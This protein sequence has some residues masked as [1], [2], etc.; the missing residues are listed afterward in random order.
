MQKKLACLFFFITPCLYRFNYPYS[1][2]QK[3]WISWSSSACVS[4]VTVWSLLHFWPTKGPSAGTSGMKWYTRNGF[5]TC[6]REAF[7]WANLSKW[8]TFLV[9]RW[10][11]AGEACAHWTFWNLKHHYDM[12]WICPMKLDYIL[13]WQVVFRLPS[14][15]TLRL[16]N[17]VWQMDLRG[18]ASRWA[19]CAE[20]NPPNQREPFSHVCWPSTAST[21]LD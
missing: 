4:L 13:L 5:R 16:I 9:I 12:I 18:F 1:G 6:R 8:K 17:P 20:W 7:P 2:G 10:K 11:S 14:T 15:L 3:T 21:Q 19:V